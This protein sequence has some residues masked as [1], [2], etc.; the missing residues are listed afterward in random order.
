MK[1]LG[2][3]G[4]L[5]RG[6]HNARLLRAAAQL[7]PPGTTLELWDGLGVLPHFNADLED[8][9]VPEVEAL[10]DALRSAH[11]LL[12]ATPEYNAS[13]P[14]PL[15][16]AVDWASRPPG[17][18]MLRG[19]PAAVIGASTSI[20]GAVW[21]QAEV[22]RVLNHVGAQVLDRELAVAT[23]H[24]AFDDDGR[25]SDTQQVAALAQL[26]AELVDAASARLGASVGAPD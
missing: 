16:N 9:Y 23:A 18:S 22:R 13:V 15:K 17:D 11:G 5:R 4:S 21:A 14:G 8:E 12:I 6:S 7:L 24:E 19:M 2:I 20:F 25:L 10:R 3:A 1:I 26:L